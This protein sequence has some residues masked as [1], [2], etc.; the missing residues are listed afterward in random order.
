MTEWMIRL[1]KRWTKEETSM[2]ILPQ[3]EWYTTIRLGLWW[4]A[5]TS[6]RY[7][8]ILS[9]RHQ[10]SQEGEHLLNWALKRDCVAKAKTRFEE[11][12]LWMLNAEKYQFA[13]PAPFMISFLCINAATLWEA[14]RSWGRVG[15]DNSTDPA[16]SHNSSRKLQEPIQ[17]PAWKFQ[18][19]PLTLTLYSTLWHTNVL[20]STYEKKCLSSLTGDSPTTSVGFPIRQM[21]VC[22]KWAGNY[23]KIAIEIGKMMRT[24]IF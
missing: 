9:C 20:F 17:P 12:K 23:P 1:P 7:R 14:D 8:D 19:S 5:A 2:A 3:H 4:L 16:S 13:P 10:T 18:W 15:S 11:I 21:Q 22:P 6:V 24:H